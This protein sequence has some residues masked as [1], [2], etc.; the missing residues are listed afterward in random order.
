VAA[1]VCTS[2]QGSMRPG[3]EE[4]RERGGGSRRPVGSGWAAGLGVGGHGRLFDRLLAGD[5]LSC[6]GSCGWGHNSY[7]AP[8][9]VAIKFRWLLR[10]S[11]WRLL[12]W[13]RLWLCLWLGSVRWR[14]RLRSWLWSW[15]RLLIGTAAWAGLP[16]IRCAF[17]FL[18]GSLPFT[19][20]AGYVLVTGLPLRRVLAGLAGAG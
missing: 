19:L 17:S 20:F 18:L 12:C 15:M 4:S 16:R 7:A 11:W 14:S 9:P 10:S 3:S 2:V 13:M 5:G 8:I 1:G 6:A